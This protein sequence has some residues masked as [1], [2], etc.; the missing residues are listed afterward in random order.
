[1]KSL[2]VAWVWV[3]A[4]LG[5]S[6]CAHHQAV[7][8]DFGRIDSDKGISTNTDLEWTIR[9]EPSKDAASEPGDNLGSRANHLLTP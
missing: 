9:H 8:R 5:L 4:S 6:A 2:V 1:M 7:P 3:L